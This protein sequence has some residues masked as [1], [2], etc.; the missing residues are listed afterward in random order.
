MTDHTSL[1]QRVETE[2]PG[3][4]LDLA[5]AIEVGA[6]TPDTFRAPHSVTG[7]MSGDG[8]GGFG[9]P[10]IPA[11]TTD[12]NAAVSLVPLNYGELDFDL[13]REIGGWNCLVSAGE[14][15][16]AVKGEGNAPTP[17]QAI[18][19]AALRARKGDEA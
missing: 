14:N 17:A 1:D 4:E 6:A 15:A 7:F 5:I 12:L 3:R 11:Y 10:S 2:E 13:T 18:V 19:A 8:R 16:W 9:C